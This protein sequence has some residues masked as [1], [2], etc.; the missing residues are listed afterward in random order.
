MGAIAALFEVGAE[1]LAGE[2]LPDVRGLVRDG[3]L[4]PVG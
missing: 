1:D 2:L 3:F 4:A